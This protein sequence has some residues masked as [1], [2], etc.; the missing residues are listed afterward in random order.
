MQMNLLA[1]K[2]L[3]LASMA[4]L[5]AA[6]PNPAFAGEKRPPPPP[7]RPPPRPR[8]NSEKPP[9]KLTLEERAKM[10]AQIKERLNKQL[11]D[12][13]KKKASSTLND[14]ERQRLER[15]E[16]LAGR[17]RNQAS[18]PAVAGA[19][20]PPPNKPPQNNSAAAKPKT[21]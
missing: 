5:L 6:L 19:L 7:L 18:N 11:S 21:K 1:A 13:Q 3:A 8:E 15:L 10:R 12:L 4:A 16:V 14:E 2:G 17:F 20:R 9:P